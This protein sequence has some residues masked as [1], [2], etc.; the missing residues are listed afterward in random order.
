MRGIIEAVSVTEDNCVALQFVALSLRLFGGRMPL[1]GP[2][3]SEIGRLELL[4]AFARP[5][6]Q[7]EEVSFVLAGPDALPG[8]RL[9][10]LRGVDG[11]SEGGFA[12]VEVPE[13]F[14][15]D[16]ETSAV[17]CSTVGSLVVKADGPVSKVGR[18]KSTFLRVRIRSQ[19]G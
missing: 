14:S 16:L 1:E 10:R 7:P 2:D 18:W 9:G 19:R 15:D 8:S 13:S 5:C 12:D 6:I 3:D 4:M 17:V 11:Q